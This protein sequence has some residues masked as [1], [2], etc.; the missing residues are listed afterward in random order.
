MTAAAASARFEFRLRPDVKQRIERAAE[1][2]HESASDFARTAV[3]ERAEKVL[4][5]HGAMTRVPAQ[6]F[7]DL[8]AALDAAPTPNAAL[9]RAAKWAQSVVERR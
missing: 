9:A 1:L 8:L 2:S 5:E 3:E 4:R 7:D 6:F